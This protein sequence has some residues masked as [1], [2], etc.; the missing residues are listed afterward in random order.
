MF[1]YMRLR[2][3]SSAV[4]M[5]KTLMFCERSLKSTLV[6]RLVKPTLLWWLKNESAPFT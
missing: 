4:S 1:A 2:T 3:A 5:P 6:M